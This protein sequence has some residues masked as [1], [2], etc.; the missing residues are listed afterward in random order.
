VPVPEGQLSGPET[1]IET[2]P[3]WIKIGTEIPEEWD[4]FFEN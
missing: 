4:L 1:L 3:Y 2:K